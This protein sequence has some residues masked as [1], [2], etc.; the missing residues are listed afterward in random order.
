[1]L[2][3]DVKGPPIKKAMVF[4]MSLDD[5]I[6]LLRELERIRRDYEAGRLSPDYD[7]GSLEDIEEEG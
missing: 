2:H 3:L 6:E 5:Y 4:N 1:M 7:P